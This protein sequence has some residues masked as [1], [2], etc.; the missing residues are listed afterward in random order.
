[1]PLIGQHLRES[2]GIPQWPYRLNPS[3]PWAQYAQ[4]VYPGDPRAGNIGLNKSIL[5]PSGNT[6]NVSYTPPLRDGYV[7]P[8][9]YTVMDLPRTDTVN[10]WWDLPGTG[11]SS[12]HSDCTWSCWVKVT[13]D[14][15]DRSAIIGSDSGFNTG[16]GIYLE[17]G[18]SPS[19]RFYRG[20]W[21]DYANTPTWNGYGV[22]H[23]IMAGNIGGDTGTDVIY[24]DGVR[25]TDNAAIAIVA[26]TE[27]IRLGTL[28]TT[29]FAANNRI[30]KAQMCNVVL[31][32]TPP[33]DELAYSLYDP[34]TR[35]GMYEEQANR[36]WFLPSVAPASGRIM[37][38][39]AGHGG[40]AGQG[41]IAGQSG[42]MAG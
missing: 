16:G 28:G 17:E 8:L 12:L 3:W 37:G 10:D 18:A 30:V 2:N 31:L 24:M 42:G 41:G 29:V 19:F 36:I 25:G 32:N 6:T 23:H 38:S 35:F 27:P 7:N 14:S 11:I 1:M 22:W 5:T 26:P 9:S 15:Q 13:D 4:A 21:N 40:L 34:A 20:K 39:I 33:T